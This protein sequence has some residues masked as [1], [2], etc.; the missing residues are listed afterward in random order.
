MLTMND[1]VHVTGMAP[2]EISYAIA[3]E[4]FPR[5]VM[6]CGRVAVPR[7]RSGCVGSKF[8]QSQRKESDVADSLTLYGWPGVRVVRPRAKRKVGATAPT[9]GAA[10]RGVATPRLEAPEPQLQAPAL[11]PRRRR[12]RDEITNVSCRKL[13]KE[14]TM[15]P[16]FIRIDE[17]AK[18]AGLTLGSAYLYHAQ[19]LYDFPRHGLQIGNVKFWRRSVVIAWVRKRKAAA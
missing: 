8:V 13:E 19:G 1:V 7:G 10:K 3:R 17:V 4:G 6:E 15:I 14:A 12:Q 5:P 11:P 2:R 16:G 9:L 18:L